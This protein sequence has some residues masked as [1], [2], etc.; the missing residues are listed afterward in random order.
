M[1]GSKFAGQVELELACPCGGKAYVIR[2]DER[3][4]G[5]LHTLPM[6]EEFEKLEPEDY[7]R[8]FRGKLEGHLDS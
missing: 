7:L 3:G 1:S 4:D 8:W 5:L 2:E 6:C